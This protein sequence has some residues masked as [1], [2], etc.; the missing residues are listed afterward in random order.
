MDVF[1]LVIIVLAVLAAIGGYRLGFFTRALSWVGLAAGVYLAVRLLAPIVSAAHLASAGSRL[2][3]AALVLIGGAFVGQALGMLVGNRIHRVLPLGP[4]RGADKVVG[5]AVGVLGVA[6][7]L[8]LLLPSITSVAGWPARAT[9][10]SVISRWLVNDF[11]HP[12]DPLESLRQLVG[13]GAF[14][15]VFDALRPGEKVGRPP[16]H[17]P[18]SRAVTARVAASTVKVE[19]QACDRLQEG[20]GFTVAHDLVVTNAHVVAG[21]PRRSTRVILPSGGVRLARVVLYDP[22][23]DLALLSVRNLDER[24]LPLTKGRVGARGSVFG[25]P[26]GQAALAIQP[27]TIAEEITAVGEDLYDHHHTSRDVFV[28][29]AS[30][31]PGDSGGALID[32]RGQVVGVAFAIALDRSDTAYALTTNEVNQVL[33]VT[34]TGRAVSTQACVG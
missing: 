33:R 25:H 19:G 31:E 32:R 27:A 20:S 11:P 28:L 9:R 22:N 12:P 10:E 16:A 4:L 7:T 34:R 6:L 13:T 2:V 3:V 14:P 1:D 8:W 23:R 26:G 17:N 24:S 30:L 15:Q 29:A 18:L 21:E 5:A